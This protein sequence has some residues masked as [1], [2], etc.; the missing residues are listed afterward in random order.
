[1]I[2][3]KKTK[4]KKPIAGL[5]SRYKNLEIPESKILDDKPSWNAHYNTTSKHKLT[6]VINCL[7]MFYF[8]TT[9]PFVGSIGEANLLGL[10]PDVEWPT[11][12]ANSNY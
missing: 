5:I 1:M 9:M 3:T 10:G 11:S 4:Y 7:D 8:K 2:F 6:A 12:A